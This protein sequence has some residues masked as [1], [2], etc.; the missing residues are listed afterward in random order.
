MLQLTQLRQGLLWIK[1]FMEFQPMLDLL[2]V[3]QRGRTCLA[4]FTVASS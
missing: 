4:S 2:E 1:L 3:Q